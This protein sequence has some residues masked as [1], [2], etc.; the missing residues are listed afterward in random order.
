MVY[1]YLIRRYIKIKFNETNDLISNALLKRKFI[2]IKKVLRLIRSL[3]AKY[4]ELNRFNNELWSKFLLLFWLLFG[5]LSVF[6]LYL[7]IFTELNIILRFIVFYGF[8]LLC[9]LFLFIINTA[10][11]VNYSANKVYKLLNQVMAY[12]RLR[13]ERFK[14]RNEML[15]IFLRKVKVKKIKFFTKKMKRKIYFKKIL[16][17]SFT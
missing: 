10:S 6:N 13:Y 2:K 1:F 8:I 14:T 17:S 4:S 12:H 3:D 9:F 5:T 7:L 15:N 11:S 16:N